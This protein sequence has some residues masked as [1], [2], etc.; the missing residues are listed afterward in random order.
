MLASFGANKLWPI[1]MMFG[2]ES[3]HRRGKS[4]LKLFEEVAY[5][6][7][8]GGHCIILIRGSSFNSNLLITLLATGRIPGLVSGALREKIDQQPTIHLP[9]PGALPGAMEDSA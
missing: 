8:V 4:S 7:T 6:Q 3:K 9:Q 5:F 2:N 1:Y